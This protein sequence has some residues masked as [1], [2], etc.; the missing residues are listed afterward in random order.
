MILVGSENKK[1]PDISGWSLADSLK[2]AAALSLH[3]KINGDGY[4]AQQKPAN[5]SAVRPAMTCH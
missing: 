5:G 2:L 4:V 3:P 1:M